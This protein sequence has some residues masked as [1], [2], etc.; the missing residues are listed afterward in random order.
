MV[1]LLLGSCAGGRPTGPGEAARPAPVLRGP[2]NDTST[3]FN[4][5]SLP[6]LTR[7]RYDGRDF[8]LEQVLARGLAFTRHAVSY[9]SGDLR[10]TGV[11][12]VPT[13]PGRAPLVVLAHGWTEPSRYRSGS[14][15]ARERELLAEHGF[16]A[17]QVDYRNHAGSSSESGD[18]VARPLGYPEDLVNAVRAVRRADLP[19]VDASRV[20]LFGRSMGGGVV[21]NALA[22]RPHL[23][24]AA[25]LYSP[26]S[27]RAADSYRR[28]VVE[29]PALQARVAGAF[30]T[31]RSRPRVWAE[32]SARSYLHRLDLPVQLHH[33]TADPVCPVGWSRATT[34][35][36]R[37]SGGHVTLHEY[38]GEGH[39]FDAAWPSF[40]HRAVS[41]LHERLR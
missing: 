6:A 12:D 26:V 34:A 29:E 17:F 22:A 36:L 19:F 15:L 35:A 33:G 1:A 31:P 16:V 24:D 32:A 18:A 38:A 37:A 2:H 27:S 40:M 13:R 30:G 9:R 20:G 21:L 7:H 11:M 25:V 4:L 28:W 39:R 14:M 23:A 10:V 5:V 3:P 41:F 8:R